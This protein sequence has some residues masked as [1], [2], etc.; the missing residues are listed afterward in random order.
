MKPSAFLAAALLAAATLAHAEIR[1]E[2]ELQSGSPAA[3]AKAR[4]L[5]P[6]VVAATRLAPF[7]APKA[8]A[9]VPGTPAQIGYPRAV[10]APKAAA[11]G[12]VWEEG[13]GNTRRAAFSVT[14]PGAAATRL[15]LRIAAAPPDTVLRFYPPS[16]EAAY[17][18]SH[19]EIEAQL[20]LGSTSGA[21]NELYWSPVVE[22]ETQVV[23][24][25]LAAG[26]S[27]AGLDLSVPSVS[28]L[29]AS[30]NEEFVVAK[31]TAAACNIDASCH[32]TTW[33]TESAAVARIV[34]TEGGSSFLCSG[35]M[36]ADRDTSTTIPWFLTANHCVNTQS[37]AS[38]IQTFWFYRST[39]CDSGVRGSF[40]TRTGGATLMYATSSTDTSFMRLNATPPAG[41]GYAGWI[42]GS[43]PSR[44]SAVTGI[45][46]PRGDLQKITFGTLGGYSTC[47][48][49]GEGFSCRGSTSSSSTFYS[50]NW[51]SGITEGGSSGSG[52]FLDSGR[53]LVGQL[54]GGSGGCGESSN[55]Y[56]GRLD[57]AYN[58]ALSQW[59]GTTAAS[60]PEPA[61]EYDYSDLWWNAGESGWGLSITQHG[62]NTIF[63]A[64]FVYD[65]SGR[66]TWVVM[67]GGSWTANNTYTG[68][69]YATQG[70]DPTGNF[71]ASRVVTTRV[72]NATLRFSA[73][74]RGTLTYTAF[75]I[76]GSKSIA[77]QVFGPFDARPI[78]SYGDLWWV[79][80]E[81][82]WGLSIT[83]QYHA[84][85]AV[86][87]SY[88]ADG[89][90]VWYVMSGGD[91]T[92]ADTYSGT[93]YRT[94]YAPR[95]FFGTGFDPSSVSLTEVGRLTL[96]F[97]GSSN[98][99]MS[100]TVNGVSGTKQIS[101]QPF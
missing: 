29:V 58:A 88:R 66:A 18:V 70:M 9:W 43:T 79:P 25:E 67:P 20:R 52:L 6:A 23:E 47:T 93:L 19:A 37:A 39:T 59:L 48:P 22:G 94:A 85:F 90:P 75:G 63:A 98:A 45:H 65:E 49:S 12:L 101:R 97:T 73:R 7:S 40:S 27:S 78:A 42:V 1:T 3:E 2:P 91:W 50:V 71:D 15:A 11:G 84:L 83:Q 44:S 74:D 13:P 24:I 64:W 33:G 17:V 26:Q 8:Q 41:A 21:A 60:T 35:T 31:A 87:Y 99:I 5:P 61:P 81:S 28:H 95:A 82:G 56:Y 62:S 96:R 53:Y 46:H 89:T 10:A 68:D 86:W 16:G 55:D 14:S 38:T 69:L 32:Q 30:A 57:V 54:Y 80:S 92:S 100:Y 76:S 36:L 34:Y 51:R 72:G 4:R 77:R